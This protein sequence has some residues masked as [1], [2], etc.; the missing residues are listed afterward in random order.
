MAISRLE[1]TSKRKNLLL[2]SAITLVV[3][4]ALTIGGIGGWV[5]RESYRNDPMFFS[6]FLES[7]QQA[8]RMPL[9]KYAISQ[10]AEQTI[11][12][13]EIRIQS[14]IDD[15]ADFT[16]YLFSYETYGGTIT[17]QLNVPQSTR[18]A[19]DGENAIVSPSPVIVMLRGYHPLPSYTTGGGTRNGAAALARAGFITIAPDFLGY[20]D[21]D[22][23]FED[24]WE[25]RLAKPA[26]ILQ[27]LETLTQVGLPLQNT[28]NQTV[29]VSV[30]DDQVGMWAH[31]NGG[32]IALSVLQIKSEPIPTTL[33]APVTAPFPYSVLY[34]GLEQADEG[35]SQRRWLAQFEDTYDVY[36]FSISR[37]MNRLTGPI[38]L[39]HG[40]ADEAAPIVWSDTFE[41]WVTAE[42]TRREQ[43][44]EESTDDTAAETET[45]IATE[46]AIVDELNQAPLS[47]IN[48][49]YYRYP[50][51]DHNMRP[52]WDQ[53]VQRDIG[54]FREELTQ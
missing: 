48:L 54:F 15:N 6:P 30:E 19:I 53:V 1:R 2:G 13:S 31:S 28:L 27:L 40:T 43:L 21:S 12:P 41:N 10:L 37:H 5:L 52:S 33:W 47:P 7:V 16:S 8:K 3:L 51:A 29:S 24:S 22:P 34:F 39:H 23:E 38:Q 26:Q 35:R 4:F 20:G 49:T 42:N 36:D 14:V 45:T 17:G 32:Q 44:L 18:E 46:T 50:G 11:P 9:Q 25:A